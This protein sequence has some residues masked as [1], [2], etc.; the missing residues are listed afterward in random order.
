MAD[1]R[2]TGL[3]Q[4]VKN[5]FFFI[6]AILFWINQAVEKWGFTT[7]TLVSSYLDDL[8]AM[9]VILGLTL[10]VFQWIHPM[11]SKFRF[12]GIQTT[13]GF[14]YVSLAFEGFLPFYSEV[15]TRDWI[16]IIC[17]GLGTIIF[18]RFI[19]PTSVQVIS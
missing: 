7:P 1:R 16:D 6:P 4:V 11:K 3:I 18:Y 5:P 12:T 10:Q 13:V 17:Y 9:P 19:N 8:L 14:L 2:A 15:Y